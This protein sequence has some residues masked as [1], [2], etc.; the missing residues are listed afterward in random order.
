MPHSLGY[1]VNSLIGPNGM[2][3]L[4]SG[5]F[6]LSMYVPFQKML[7]FFVKNDNGN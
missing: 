2:L 4:S 5:R 6:S 1:Y 7:R 3:Y